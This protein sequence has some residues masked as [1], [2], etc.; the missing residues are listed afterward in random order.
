MGDGA[1]VTMLRADG[2]TVRIGTA[3]P[4]NNVR[5]GT[6]VRT[7]P[8]AGGRAR[9]GSAVTLIPSAGPRMIKVPAVAGQQLA[10]AQAALRSAG[11]TP[12]GRV[13]RAISST[14]AAGVV[15][16]TQPAGG[17]LWP[18]PQP[19]VITVSEG[20]P[21]PNFIGQDEQ[22]IRQW[23]AQN[24]ITL[25]VTPDSG[26]SQPQ[27][28]ITRQSPAPGTPI[29]ANETVT[30][31]VSSGPPQ[32]AI[33]NVDGMNVAQARQVLQQAGFTVTVNRFGPFDKVFDYNPN[34]QALKGSTITIYVGF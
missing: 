21:L 12:S 6:V 29:T 2:F 20:P 25:N 10:S 17:T 18:Q 24:G 1:A 31:G 32:V 16:S 3:Q 14:V 11:L 4:D 33:P 26:S 13:R 7:I 19:V 28:I 30:V 9:K 22:T 34:G 5:Q 27:G 15:I 23:A 8:A